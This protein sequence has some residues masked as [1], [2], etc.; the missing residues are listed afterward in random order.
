MWPQG[1]CGLIPWNWKLWLVVG[2]PVHEQ[3]GEKVS[4]MQAEEKVSY[5]QVGEE[6]SYMQAEEKASHEQ[7][8][9]LLAS[10][11]QR[12][13]MHQTVQEL[14]WCWLWVW[15]MT[16]VHPCCPGYQGS[17]LP[18]YERGQ[19]ASLVQQIKSCPF[20]CRKPPC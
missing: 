14:H 17:H 1:D 2:L 19:R 9:L 6:A 7:E 13:W 8:S 20:C 15:L 3:A 11:K 16:S 12:K 10:E 4:Y 5:V 18:M